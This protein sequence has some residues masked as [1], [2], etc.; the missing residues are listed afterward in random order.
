MWRLRRAANRAPRSAPEIHD[1]DFA[2]AALVLQIEAAR[3][4]DGVPDA[5]WVPV[6]QLQRLRRAFAERLLSTE[7]AD[8]PYTAAARELLMLAERDGASGR[9]TTYVR[10]TRDARSLLAP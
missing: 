2:M 10:L 3:C 7:A 4:A 8:W 9:A 1:L 5:D 6:A